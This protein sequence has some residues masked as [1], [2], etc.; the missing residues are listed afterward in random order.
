M[1]DNLSSEEKIYLLGL[2]RQALELGVRGEALPD[3]DITSVPAGLLKPG[4]TFVT[5]TKNAELRGCI[6]SLEAIRP[7]AEDV[8]VHAVA[9]ALE[10]YRFPP[11]HTNEVTQILI[12]ISRLTAPKRIDY[13]DTDELINLLRPGL[14]G[15]VIQR[16]VQR[17]TFL[18][19]VWEKVPD[20]EIFLAMLCRKMGLSSDC[21]RGTDVKIST[22]RVEKFS[23]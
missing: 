5:L 1:E 14:D 13:R 3:L 22:Y 8:R 23:E 15:V 2:A 12:E 19:Q 20:V 10:D 4:A 18:P 17:A 7:L 16:G 21:W 6:G 9:A 11:V